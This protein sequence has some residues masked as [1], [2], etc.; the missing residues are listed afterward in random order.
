M[1]V[2]I[3]IDD[4]I[5][6]VMNRHNE[7]CTT[8]CDLSC[9]SQNL[10]RTLHKNIENKKSDEHLCTILGRQLGFQVCFKEL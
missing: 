2:L 1:R 6:L 7:G 5:F 4:R 9:G 10:C 8:A 3:E